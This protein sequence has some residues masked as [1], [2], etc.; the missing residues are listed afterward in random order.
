[1]KRRDLLSLVLVTLAPLSACKPV[2]SPEAGE[3][4]T[5]S[6]TRGAPLT[7]VEFFSADCPCQR[8]HD[9]RLIA[10]HDAYAPRGV[11]F[12]AIDAEVGA[13]PERAQREASSRGYPFA[14]EP[15]PEGK[16]ADV[17]DARFATY[18]V[19]L[20]RDG[21][22]RYQGG[23]DSDRKDLHDDAQHYVRDALD[24]LLGGREVR[25]P[26]G[27]TLGCSLRRR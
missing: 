6:L 13:S 7:V 3:E 11:R 4:R 25:T 24:D 20:D 21:V 14:I 19:V 8:A 15:D 2:A 16:L 12:V 9:A 26:E 5:R 18:T 22:V 1:M 27:K 17:L 23:V 10:L